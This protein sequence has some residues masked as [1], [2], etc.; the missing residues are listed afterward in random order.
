MPSLLTGLTDSANQQSLIVLPN[1]STVTLNL[2]F[3]P[4]QVGWYMQLIWDGQVPA[5]HIDTMQ[6]LTA[7]NL[8]RQWKEVIPFGLG[9]TTTNGL[10]PTT[11]ESLS[12]GTCSVY[13]L[14]SSDVAYVDS[15]FVPGN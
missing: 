15:V 3:W 5:F 9:V 10:D 7:P 13:L 14:N 12:D 4:Q 6:L 8:L 11:Q 1:G 2:E